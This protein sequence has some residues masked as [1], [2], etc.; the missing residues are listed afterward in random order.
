MGPAGT[1]GFRSGA[2]LAARPRP[3]TPA[4]S[5]CGFV[6]PVAGYLGYAHRRAGSGEQEG[7]FAVNAQRRCRHP[8]RRF[9]EI[10]CVEP[11]ADLEE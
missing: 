8:L 7:L 5:P 10:R 9:K 3:L 2:T 1:D 6:S 11:L 4:V